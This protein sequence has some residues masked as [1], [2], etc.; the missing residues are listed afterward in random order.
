MNTNNGAI[1]AGSQ[2]DRVRTRRTIEQGLVHNSESPWT[3]RDR[4]ELGTMNDDKL[5]R[6]AE[7]YGVLDDIQAAN[8]ETTS[9]D[10]SGWENRAGKLVGPTD[11]TTESYNHSTRQFEKRQTSNRDSGSSDD[12]SGWENRAGKRA[13]MDND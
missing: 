13:G 9:G 2:R 6:E 5:V 4:M 7:K 11:N 3:N 8:A 10:L 1:N 12:L